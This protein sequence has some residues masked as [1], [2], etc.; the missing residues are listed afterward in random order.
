[1]KARVVALTGGIGAGKSVVSHALRA[2]GYPVYDCDSEARRLTDSSPEILRRIADEI[3]PDA[4]APDGRLLRQE[5]ADVVFA[6][7]DA[8]ARLNS[9]VHG[10]VRADLLQRLEAS[11]SPLWFVET[12]ILYESGFD[13]LAD[14][15]WEVTA[16]TEER[17]ARVM[18]RN[19]LTRGQV[20]S[21][22]ASQ[23]TLSRPHHR[24]IHN[25]STDALIP[26][27]LHELRRITA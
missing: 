26:Q 22:M 16:P 10:A 12:A 8:L 2:M 24:I 27:I 19:G 13:S 23:Q 11:R 25:S 6:D 7:A 20:L 17:V 1:M 3:T 9:I 18:A 21:R 15:V 5:L 14:E 4:I